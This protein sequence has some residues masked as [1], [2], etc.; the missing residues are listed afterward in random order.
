MS[1]VQYQNLLQPL[2]V[3]VCYTRT[4]V[5]GLHNCSFYFVFFFVFFN[6]AESNK[7]RE[8]SRFIKKETLRIRIFFNVIQQ[9]HKKS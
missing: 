3:A 7:G 5:R 2:E 1:R 8:S 4:K 9:P 6:S